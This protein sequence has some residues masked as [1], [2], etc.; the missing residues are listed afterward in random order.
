MIYLFNPLYSDRLPI[1]RDYKKEYSG[2]S[3]K[4][5]MKGIFLHFFGFVYTE[6]N[7]TEMYI[8]GV[9]LTFT[10]VILPYKQLIATKSCLNI[11]IVTLDQI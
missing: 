8:F 4:T 11:E 7:I 6:K 1:Q 10:T 3:L 2:P 5:K 9:Y